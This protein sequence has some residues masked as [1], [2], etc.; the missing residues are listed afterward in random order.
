[1][2]DVVL[3]AVI[4]VVLLVTY[5]LKSN[6]VLAFLALCAGYTAVAFINTLSIADRFSLSVGSN[7]LGG[8]ITIVLPVLT[9]LICRGPS[10]RKITSPKVFLNLLMALGLGASAILIITPSLFS[11]TGKTWDDSK[12]WSGLSSARA[13]V[14][15]TSTLL[16]LILLYLGH[17]K[18]RSSDKHGK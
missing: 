13:W 14:V 7:A 3:I 18:S 11:I 6:A 1:M 15:G 2:V 4:L 9:L 10:S 16:A 8:L 12:V 17:R 5:F